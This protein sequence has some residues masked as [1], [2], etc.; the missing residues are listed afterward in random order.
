MQYQR[1][2]RVPRS[3][4]TSLPSGRWTV[5]AEAS[6]AQFAIRHL[7]GQ[8]TIVGEFPAMGGELE[9][10]RDGRVRGELRIDA[11]SIATGNPL[12]HKHLQSAAW[13]AAE[14]HREIT[15]IPDEMR[16]VD[17]RALRIDG[18]LTVAGHDEPLR[19]AS[20][21]RARD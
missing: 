5:D 19:L 21:I 11:T 2:A 7:W 20:N 15:F 13:L 17:Q 10:D 4:V 16:P 8:V 18:M 6:K 9:I 1:N 12:R 3:L 14:K